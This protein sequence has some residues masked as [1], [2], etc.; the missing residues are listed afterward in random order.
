[1]RIAFSRVIDTFKLQ[2]FPVAL[3]IQPGVQSEPLSE[4]RVEVCVKHGASRS[5]GEHPGLVHHDASCI[6]L[7]HKSRLSVDSVQGIVRSE[8]L[9]GDIH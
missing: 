7:P 8:R 2:K 3:E 5:P 1:M 9:T 4:L 6:P